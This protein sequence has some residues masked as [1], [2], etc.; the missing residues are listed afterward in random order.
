ML[1]GMVLIF[2]TTRTGKIFD[3]LIVIIIITRCFKLF[4]CADRCLYNWLK[5]GGSLNF[6]G[7]DIEALPLFDLVAFL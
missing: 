7:L 2:I 6:Q 1:V 3:L 4:Y 5:I